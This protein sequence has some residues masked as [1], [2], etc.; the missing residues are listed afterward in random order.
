MSW[1]LDSFAAAGL[2]R[3]TVSLP[4]CGR[5]CSRKAPETTSYTGTVTQ[6][7]L[8]ESAGGP[9]GF[10]RL[11]INTHQ[12]DP[13]PQRQEETNRNSNGLLGKQ[14]PLQPC[15]RSWFGSPPQCS[16]NLWPYWSSWK[17]S[18]A[19][20]W[21][22]TSGLLKMLWTVLTLTLLSLLTNIHQLRLSLQDST[23]M[24]F[25]WCY[26]DYLQPARAQLPHE[27]CPNGQLHH[28]TQQTYLEIA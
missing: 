25:A 10:K 13:T 12:N 28:H 21:A 26:P 19:Q 15:G 18:N 2:S 20:R 4:A 27:A 22:M 7:T 14:G 1:S 24:I 11:A 3:D 16:S 9:M 8:R 17:I 23:I 5:I 6:I